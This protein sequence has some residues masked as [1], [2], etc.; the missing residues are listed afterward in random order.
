MTEVNSDSLFS[1][2]TFGKFLAIYF[3]YVVLNM[4]LGFYGV[5]SDGYSNYIYF[6]IGLAIAYILLLH[7]IRHFNK[8]EINISFL[9][10]YQHTME[11]NKITNFPHILQL[12]K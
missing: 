6:Y 3:I 7:I 1:L 4:I 11:R 9:G 2:A 10:K 8:N 12:S 5:E